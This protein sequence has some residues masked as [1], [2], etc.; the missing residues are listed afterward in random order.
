[1]LYPF[2]CF[3]M[4]DRVVLRIMKQMRQLMAN[5]GHVPHDRL[6]LICPDAG[7]VS[8]VILLQFH[9]PAVKDDL[10]SGAKSTATFRLLVHE[11]FI[12]VSSNNHFQ[13]AD[14]KRRLR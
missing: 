3:I 13:V 5:R 6:Q 1:M 12:D 8:E 10:T 2:H 14:F 4:L 7:A 9:I 11:D